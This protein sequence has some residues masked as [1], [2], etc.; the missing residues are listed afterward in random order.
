MD[1]ILGLLSWIGLLGVSESDLDTKPLEGWRRWLQKFIYRMGRW[2]FFCMGI[3]KLKITGEKVK[4][5]KIRGLYT[6]SV[7]QS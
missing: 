1:W 4:N 2:G 5:L 3:H 6:N 7:K